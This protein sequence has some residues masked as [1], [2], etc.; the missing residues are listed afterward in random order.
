MDYKVKY[1]IYAWKP[2]DNEP[3]PLKRNI[4]SETLAEREGQSAAASGEYVRVEMREGSNTFF[5]QSWTKCF[6]PEL[7]GVLV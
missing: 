6:N 2:G 4:E 5:I 3:R 1:H 7:Q